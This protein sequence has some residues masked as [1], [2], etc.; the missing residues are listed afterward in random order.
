MC[1]LRYSAETLLIIS[2]YSV[3]AT[4]SAAA[5]SC[6][7]SGLAVQVL[8]LGGPEMQDKRA[9]TSYLIWENGRVRVMVPLTRVTHS[10]NANKP[11]CKEQRH[12]ERGLTKPT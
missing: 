6:G 1:P 11:R 8:G 12:P 9:S 10:A 7:S 4:L 3:C 5:H 2:L